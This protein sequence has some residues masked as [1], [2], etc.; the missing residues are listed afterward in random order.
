MATAAEL[1]ARRLAE[2]GCSRVF[3]IPGGEVL[4]LMEALREA[5]LEFVLTKHENSGGF[6][7][8]GL[9]QAS[10]DLPV[11]L[12]TL[13]PGV[14]NAVNVVANARLDRVPL[15]FLTGAVD[16]ADRQTYTHQVIDHAAILRPVVKASFEIHDGAAG[17]I[18]ENAVSL[19]RE[20]PPGP[21]HI[22]LPIGLA[23]KPQPDAAPL[24]QPASIAARP[25]AG[26]ELAAARALLSGAERPLILAGVE[27]LE[28]AGAVE[29]LR[30]LARQFSIPVITT[31]KAKG[32]FPE[33]DPLSLGAAGLSP[34]ADR[35]L[36][37]LVGASDLILLA[38][39]DPV[40]MRH[41]WTAAWDPA[42]K[43]VIE[44]SGSPNRHY[45]HTARIAMVGDIA[46]GLRTLMHDLPADQTTWPGGEAAQARRDLTAAF[47]GDEDWG[48]AAIAD[49]ICK[50]LP[51]GG[52]ATVD[53]GAHRI[54]LS[55][56]WRCDAPGTL[57][58]S[59]GLATMGCA[60]PLAIGAKLAAPDKAVVAVMGDACLE[61]VLGELAT[62]RDLK[63]AVVVVVYVDRS[64]ALIEMKQR[65]AQLPNLGVDFPGTDFPSVARALGGAGVT[66]GDRGA[67]AKA[68]KG[69]LAADGFTIIAAEIEARA[70][71][72]RI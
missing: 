40:E 60:L 54:V 67:L 45:V 61:M 48:P 10:G 37:K 38:G 36:I 9:W 46:A 63:L 53:S 52:I 23:G 39:Y 29:A 27:A 32:V 28:F 25:V 50:N 31:Y 17:A 43:P 15:I 24:R 35:F 72:G 19:A 4:T 6:M 41:N 62:L 18:V 68:L 14:V 66:V 59:T 3:G 2:A 56:V 64:L 30:D 11:L 12:A 8:E 44:F 26:D 42:E 13:G 58:Q 51:A 1:I 55:H 5:G 47:R 65:G 71:D 33:G 20:N 16:P 22:D 7:A 70:Y 49:E 69:G 34:L 21:V 57:L